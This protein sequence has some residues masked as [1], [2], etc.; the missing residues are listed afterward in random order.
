MTDQ[1]IQNEILDLA[2]EL[3][4]IPSRAGLDPVEPILQALARWFAGR[5]I[6][7]TSITG[8]LG[9]D[10]GMFV[11]IDSGREGPM[12]CLDACLDT[13]PF[14][15]EEAWTEPPTGAHIHDGKLYGRGAADS[16]V[17]VAT[18]AVLTSILKETGELPCGSLYTV[19]DADEHSGEFEGIK[20]FLRQLERKPE[21]MIIGYP[22]NDALVAGSRGFLRAEVTVYGEGAHAGS[23]H[24][25]GLNAI[26]RMVDLVSAIRSTQLPAEHDRR[27][28]F[29]PKV[30]VTEIAGGEGFSIVPDR[31][32]CKLDFRLTPHVGEGEGR[33]WIT[34]IVEDLDRQAPDLRT[35][36]ITWKESWPAFRVP[37]DS[38]LVERFRLTAEEVFEK[39]IPAIVSG[40]SN[41]GNYLA[42]LGIPALSGFGV[43]NRNIHAPNEFAEINSILPVFQTYRRA[44]RRLV[45]RPWDAG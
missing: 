18:F 7:A 2:R 4:R 41:I 33:E 40:P 32:S 3:I 23:K 45:E 14:G 29:G 12:V 19:F 28:W 22:G 36:L 1:E 43:T 20:G 42:S 5:G 34:N 15:D 17:A 13:A 21:C 38:P 26:Y 10:V 35:S 8:P 6:S 30:T 27:F 16:K 11:R 24:Q 31:C 39:K 37:D 9:D 25:K 44:I